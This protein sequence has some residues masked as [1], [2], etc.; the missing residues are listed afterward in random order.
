MQIFITGATGFVGRALVLRL[1]RD[2]H[3][4]R[5]WV[6]S[7]RR[8]ADLLGADVTLVDAGGGPQAMRAGVEGCDA[9]VNLAGESVIGKRWTRAQKQ[10]L[11]GSRVALTRTLVDAIAAADRRPQVLV[12][13]SAVGYYGDRGD[14]VVDERSAPADDFLAGL[15]VAWEAEAT[16]AEALGV[17]V[18]CPRFGLVLGPGGG[19]LARLLPVF[20]AGLGG[21]IGSGAQWFPWVHL[22]DVVELIARAVGGSQLRGPLLATAPG[23]VRNREFTAALGRALG[24]PAV[25][26]VP[27]FA[28]KLALGEAASSLLA[29]QRT[30][31][32]HTRAQGFEFRFPDLDAALADLTGDADAPRIEPADDPPDS[33]Y[34]RR[35]RPTHVLRHTVTVAAPVEQVFAFF[36]RAENLGIM[37]PPDAALQIRT[38]RPIAVGVGAGIDYTLKL[39]PVRVPWR[40]EFEAWE[41]GARF[42]DVQLRGPYRAWWHEHRFTAIDGRTTRME[43]RVYYAAPLGPLG[44]LVNRLFVAP[45]LRAIF[46]Y[47]AHAIA[48]RF[49]EPGAGAAAR[50]EVSSRA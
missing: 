7:P 44:R 47:R 28:L 43:D 35:R 20:R 22:D 27:A 33:P 50:G 34:L 45:K 36:S 26:P 11:W 21:P 2:G 29:G 37:T 5:A 48:L 9:V 3:S 1:Q 15:C 41:P 12:S 30:A 19:V 18:C 6:R 31:P 8:A 13:T 16:R 23:V 49:G 25:L 14:E 38:P 40:T 17:R 10:V 46:G 24:R 32:I 42:V 4:V 39:G